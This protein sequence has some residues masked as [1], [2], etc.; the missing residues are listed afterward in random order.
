MKSLLPWIRSVVAL[1][2][3]VVSIV[4]FHKPAELAFPEL[5]AQTLS[6]DAERSLMLLL[7]FLAGLVGSVVVGLIARHRL[8]LHMAIFFIIMAVFDVQAILGPFASQPVWFKALVLGAL[9]FQA[10][11]GGLIAKAA[12]PGA[13][14]PAA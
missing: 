5:Y 9:P 7:I 2:V 4:L 1:I 14:R 3:G 11:L 6:S 8:W 12:C 10:W 13:C